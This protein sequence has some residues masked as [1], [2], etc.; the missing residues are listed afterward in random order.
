MEIERKYYIEADKIPQLWSILLK[1]GKNGTERQRQFKAIYWDTEEKSLQKLKAVYRTRQEGDRFV[2]SI[3]SEGKIVDGSFVRQEENIAIDETRMLLPDLAPFRKS[4]FGNRLFKLVGDRK[5]EEVMRIDVIR[6]SVEMAYGE[7]LLEICI[8]LGEIRSNN[9]TLQVSEL[10]MEIISGR[11]K[12]LLSLG[13]N[14]EDKY[15]LRPARESK[16]VRGLQIAK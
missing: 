15:G 3:K 4:D 8:D 13:R 16:F 12:D 9:K 7:S 14:F 6:S 2:A 10:E 1:A 5:L 11:A